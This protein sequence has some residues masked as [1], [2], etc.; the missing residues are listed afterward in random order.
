MT[1]LRLA[2]D[3]AT[4]RSYDASG[5]LHVAA[6]NICT[7]G[8]SEYLGSEIPNAS[9]LGLSLDR[10]YK[11]L[12]PAEELS[13]PETI[14]SANGLPILSVHEPHDARSHQPELVIGATGTDAAWRAPFLQVGLVFWPEHSI[15]MIAEEIRRELSPGYSYDPVVDEPGT[16][17][18]E[19]YDI[20]MKN[21]LFNHVALV[22]AGRQGPQVVVGDSARSNQM[23]HHN[24]FRGIYLAAD[25][26][27][28]RR[29]ARD[30]E[31]EQ[32]ELDNEPATVDDLLAVV[33][34]WLID[35]TP[36]EKEEFFEGVEKLEAGP[37]H[38]EGLDRAHRG[39]A[40]A[41][42]ARGAGD[43]LDRA[44]RP[45][46]FG[47][48]HRLAGDALPRGIRPASERFPGLARITTM[49]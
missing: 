27:I 25:A 28:R 23:R 39:V 12:R 36:E 1:R 26:A 42:R 9:A 38:Q 29:R 46:H 6:C 30:A 41:R 47:D 17:R 13:K 32:A 4:A 18:G 49:G 3:R 33:E 14:R 21:I 24:T 7:A 22:D 43:D 34:E 31:P 15:K 16:H 8:V 10:R 19:H 5:R 20:W 11:L 45:A 40:G 44:H 37:E 2:L 48:R 35:L